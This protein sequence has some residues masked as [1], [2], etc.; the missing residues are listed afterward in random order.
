[1][2]IETKA[3]WLEIAAIVLIAFA[4]VVWLGAYP[5]LAWLNGTLV[6]LVFCPVDG[7][8]TLS[9]PAAR[10][11]S[12]ISGGLMAGWGTMLYLVASRLFRRDP[13][14]ARELIL[15]GTGIWFVVDSLGSAVAGAPLNAL[16]NAGF[17]MMFYLPLMV[18]DTV[19][20]PFST[21]NH[22]DRT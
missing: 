12:A 18:P 11:M 14:L 2:T 15:Y 17:L 9:D 16:L 22:G 6:D 20:T 19:H 10:L 21:A 3:R 5:P 8:P 4:P 1:M 7:Q 13:A